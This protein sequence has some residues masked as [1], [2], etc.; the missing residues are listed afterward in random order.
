MRDSKRLQRTP[1][2][3][4]VAPS[5]EH[6]NEAVRRRMTA[7]ASAAHELST[8][9][10]VMSG[11]TDLLISQKL[12]VLNEAQLKVLAEMQQSANRLQHFIHDFLCFSALESGKFKIRVE[13][14]DI[15]L[16]VAEI[17]SLWAKRFEKHNVDCTFSPDPEIQVLHFDFLKIQHAISNLLDNALKFTPPG[18]K[19]KVS[20]SRHFWER[21]GEST[22]TR[23]PSTETRRYS[24][25]RRGPAKEYNSIRIS[26]TDTGIGVAPEYHQEIFEDFRRLDTTGKSRGM[27][28]GLGIARRLV[29]VHNGKIW[30]EGQLGQGSTFSF[31]I[32]LQEAV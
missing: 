11:Y 13:T 24:I 32:P 2:G 1:S 26:V 9:L 23:R 3:S 5:S 31:L 30:V 10:S 20:I 17:V 22:E 8:P 28:L 14:G 27:G 7:L 4:F 19:V 21:R 25:D 16:C 18:G 15:N 6:S 12:G 29:E